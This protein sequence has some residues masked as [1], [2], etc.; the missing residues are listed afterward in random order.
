MNERIPDSPDNNDTPLHESGKYVDRKRPFPRSDESV[1]WGY[2]ENVRT[3]DD[4]QKM[5]TMA[6]QEENE[7]GET[8]WFKKSV[9]EVQIKQLE[10]EFAA[11]R[12]AAEARRS[13]LAMGETISQPVIQQPEVSDRSNDT[14]ESE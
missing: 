8:V 7:A 4:G 2:P 14:P 12:H 13:Q 9:P 1:S 6:W 5:I 10:A 3:L 11:K